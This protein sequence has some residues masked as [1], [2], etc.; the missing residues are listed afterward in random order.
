MCSSHPVGLWGLSGSCSFSDLLSISLRIRGALLA[1]NA[2]S[3]SHLYGMADSPACIRSIPDT[4]VSGI[5]IYIHKSVLL[6][7]YVL[8]Y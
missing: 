5:L 3:H 2:A 1:E 8:V 7:G 4:A 6:E